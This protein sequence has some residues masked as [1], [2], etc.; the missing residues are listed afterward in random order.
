MRRRE[1]LQLAAGALIPAALMACGRAPGV[2]PNER[3]NVR[4][5]KDFGLQ[6][7]TVNRLMMQDFEG[8]LRKVAEIGYSQVEF[9]AMGFLGRSAEYVK[10]LL[11]ELGLNAPVGRVTP[12]LPEGVMRM[13]REEAMRIFAERGQAKH[14]VEN[15]SHGMEDALVLGQK[16]INLPFLMPAEFQSL[17]QVKRN[18]EYMNAAGE[19]C[20]EQGIMFG[21]HNHDWEFIPLDGVI[22]Y[23]LMIEQTDPQKVSF[24]LDSYWIVKGGGSFSDYLSR[25]AGR[26]NSCH[27]K[28]MDASGD[29]EDVGY[30]AIDFPSFVAEAQAAGARY[31][32]VERDDPPDPAAAIVRSYEYLRNLTY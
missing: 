8:T 15:V 17:D 20:A 22:P 9:S 27:L 7:S 32:F 21:Y 12:A 19:L 13:P 16:V 1:L 4:Q 2:G 18:I 25:Y 6:L 14:L 29:F 3:E 26:F 23:D 28:D 24:Q 10:G 30:G 11:A 31:F 5:L